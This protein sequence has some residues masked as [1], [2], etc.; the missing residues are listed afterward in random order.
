MASRAVA[1][2]ELRLA[3]GVPGRRRRH[4]AAALAF[5]AGN[6]AD[7]GAA[8]AGRGRPADRIGRSAAAALQAVDVA[9][10]VTKVAK[11][12]LG[13]EMAGRGMY[14]ARAIASFGD[15][16]VARQLILVAT[17]PTGGR[18]QAARPAIGREVQR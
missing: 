10:A 14:H 17:A 18:P 11:D 9:D 1:K 7:S 4:A 15:R 2:R 6:E 16:F 5:G 13:R 8:R 12:E 3:S